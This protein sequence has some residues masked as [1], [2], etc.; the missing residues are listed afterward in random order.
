MNL[1]ED[2]L[3]G[4]FIEAFSKDV[5]YRHWTIDRAYRWLVPFIHYNQCGMYRDSFNS[6]EGLLGF[7]YAFFTPKQEQLARTGDLNCLYE[8][9]TDRAE[10]NLFI[11][12]WMYSGSDLRTA[13]RTVNT[14]LRER[15]GRTE[16]FGFRRDQNDKLLALRKYGT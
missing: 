15:T 12:D 10:T 5:R 13:T 16:C 1:T 3:F 6:M 2:Q 8:E 4:V 14:H 7:T 11:V 9:I